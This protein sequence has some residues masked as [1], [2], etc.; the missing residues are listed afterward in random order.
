ML[1]TG[2]RKAEL[3]HSHNPLQIIKIPHFMSMTVNFEHSNWGDA[4]HT[5]Q[6]S[7]P[8]TNILP[9]SS[10]WYYVCLGALL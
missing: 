10:A 8:G 5:N 6:S 7:I 9:P 4:V 3:S 2:R 1:K